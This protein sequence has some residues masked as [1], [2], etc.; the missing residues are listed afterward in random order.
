MSFNLDLN[1]QA[2][3]VIFSRKLKNS[4]HPKIFFNATQGFKAN[5]QN[6]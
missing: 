5:W 1:K 4:S 2:P 6:I 3:E